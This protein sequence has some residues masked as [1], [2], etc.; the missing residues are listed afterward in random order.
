MA[1]IDLD[2]LAYDIADLIDRNGY[3]IDVASSHIRA[4]LP[5]FIRQIQ[6]NSAG[7]DD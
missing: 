5:D 7:D 2:M 6:Q 4:A 3:Q 1:D